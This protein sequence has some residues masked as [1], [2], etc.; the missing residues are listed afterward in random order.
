MLGRQ[1]ICVVSQYCKY[2][3]I[4]VCFL[5]H[6][7][8]LHRIL[9]VLRPDLARLFKTL[10]RKGAIWVSTKSSFV[11]FLFLSLLLLLHGD[12]LIVALSVQRAT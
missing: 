2:D 5:S 4:L 12:L 7:N 1:A 9:I 10:D 8:R 3:R 11:T 6:L